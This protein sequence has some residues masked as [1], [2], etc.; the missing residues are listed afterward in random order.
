MDLA[1]NLKASRVSEVFTIRQALYIYSI[2]IIYIYTDISQV[3]VFLLDFD[4]TIYPP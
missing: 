2:Y 1:V 3:G 4:K